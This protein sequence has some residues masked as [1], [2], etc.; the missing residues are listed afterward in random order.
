[1]DTW[2]WGRCGA[3]SA[4]LSVALGAFGA[5]ALKD[6][7]GP[8]SPYQTAV[9]YQFFHALGLL[10]L[11]LSA[12]GGALVNLIGGSFV[13]GSVIFCGSLYVLALSS[14]RWVGFLTPVGGLLFLGG[15]LGFAF[16]DRG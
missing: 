3:I 9:L 10:I 1:M 11:G 2:G 12:R 6:R 16:L 4:F 14:I 5:H 13:L 7:L 8:N 15:W